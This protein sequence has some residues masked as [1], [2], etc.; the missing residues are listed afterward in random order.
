MKTLIIPA[1]A[2]IALCAAGCGTLRQPASDIALTGAGG[3]IGYEASGKKIK[4]AAIGAG[5]G[6]VV[7]K[8]AGNEI[9]AAISDAEKRG[10]DRALNQAVKQQ[11]WIIQNMQRGDFLDAQGGA[12]ASAPRFV[13][14]L[15]PETAT[16]DGVILKPFAITLRAE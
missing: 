13:R 6:Y 3:A 7:S 8:I 12:P 9:D 15:L 11:Y 14:V 2:I 4:G 1:F 5:A 10:Y 16:E